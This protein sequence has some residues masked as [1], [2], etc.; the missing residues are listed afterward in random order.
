MSL[1][2]DN[3]INLCVCCKQAG[4]LERLEIISKHTRKVLRCKNCGEHMHWGSL[5]NEYFKETIEHFRN[6]EK[7]MVRKR[8]EQMTDFDEKVRI[9]NA[10]A[11]RATDKA[12][13]IEIE[14]DEYVIPNSQIDDDSEVY[15]VGQTGTLVISAWIAQK[16]GLA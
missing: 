14:G 9:D 12:L 4:T 3:P 10:T 15:K 13:I 2:T 1:V 7:H 6:Q 16:K 8:K 11:L 5:E